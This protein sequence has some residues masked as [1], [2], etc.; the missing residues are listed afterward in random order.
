MTPSNRLA[1]D[2]LR[3][4]EALA[5]YCNMKDTPE[6]YG[7]FRLLYPDFFPQELSAWMYQLAEEWHK[8]HV[9]L[10]STLPPM[11]W[12]RNR[13]RHVWARTDQHGYNLATLLGFDQEAEA[14]AEAHCGEIGFEPVTR[15]ALI[16][17]RP[18]KDALASQ[19]RGFPQGKA[20]VD[21]VTGQIRWEFGCRLQQA[22]YELMQER[23]RAKICTCGKYFVAMKTAQKLC[24]AR[25]SNDAKR[26][27]ARTWWNEEG[28]ER[29]SKA[30]QA[31]ERKR[32]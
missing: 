11:L 22:I 31:R 25:C 30:R 21:G 15:T 13:L 5:A 23:W 20:I 16:P 9:H 32:R 2:K 7:R 10:G 4:F 28:N 26:E 1:K 17:G 12:Y 14:I 3:L 6:D 27:R 8:V 18:L 24:S 29:R 19:A